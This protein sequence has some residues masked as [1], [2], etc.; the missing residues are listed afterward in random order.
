MAFNFSRFSSFQDDESQSQSGA[1]LG[2]IPMVGTAALIRQDRSSVFSTIILLSILCHLFLVSLGWLAFILMDFFD[3]HW[4]TFDPLMMKSRDIEFVLVDKPPAPPRN[5]NT[6]N[7][8]DRASRSGGKEKIND[9]TSLATRQAGS[10]S[11]KAQK[12]TKPTPK[13][14]S[15]PKKPV[16]KRAVKKPT[17]KKPAPKKP[18]PRPPKP[19]PKVPNLSKRKAP[20][21]PP[22]PI[23]PTIK[24]PSV[25]TPNTSKVKGP[26]LPSASSG[27]S[28]NLS[29]RPSLSPTQIAGAGSYRPS[30]GSR[31]SAA[32]SGGSSRYNQS[33][34]AGGGGG[35]PGIDAL[36]D[37]DYGAYMSELQRRI[38]RNWR[39]PKAQEDKRVKVYFRI[40]RDG[41]LLSLKIAHSSGYREA[42]QAALA[43]VRLSAPFR[44]LP[45]GERKP[46]LPIEFTFDYN[47]YRSRG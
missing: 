45:P 11:S 35:A 8:S 41:R 22:N 24:T 25:P 31:A 32:G 19:S 23:A 13:P 36:P 2:A 42:D 1:G 46:D 44:P 26:V 12:Q 43:A 6:K 20:T 14:V 47:V 4:I 37:P 9:S 21:L 34:R 33:G 38:K 28:S 17:P 29:R 39:P 40:A 10:V 18:T 27:S 5:P 30:R 15:K 7:R 3:L 16:A